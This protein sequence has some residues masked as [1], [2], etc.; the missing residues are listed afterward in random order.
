MTSCGA[1]AVRPDPQAARQPAPPS[2]RVFA[3]RRAVGARIQAARFHANLTREGLAERAGLDCRSVNRIERRHAS[4][5]VDNPV[6]I[7]D[8]LGVPLRDLV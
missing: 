7:A 5:I 3:A 1:R 6:R 8:A 2:P 4:P